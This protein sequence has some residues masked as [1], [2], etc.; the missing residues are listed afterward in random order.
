MIKDAR[1]WISLY[2]VICLFLIC[3]L[4]MSGCS[5]FKQVSV[6]PQ[7]PVVQGAYAQAQ[8]ELYFTWHDVPFGILIDPACKTEKE[9]EDISECKVL[10]CFDVQG[11][12]KCV[13]TEPKKDQENKPTPSQPE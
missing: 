10:V 8:A 1:T 7:L 4:F 12:V 5:M 2:G 6:K 11:Y 9:G 3:G 13:K